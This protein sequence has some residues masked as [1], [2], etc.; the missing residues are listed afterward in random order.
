M[1]CTQSQLCAWLTNGLSGDDADN[2]TLLNHAAGRQVTAVALCADTFAGLASEH[3]TNLNLFNR[4]RVY[5]VC[6][7][8][9]D[10]LAS[11]YDKVAS[12]R[13]E[14]VVNGSP[15]KNSLAKR[16]DDLVLVLDCRSH[17]ASQSAAVFLGD[18]HI[19]R[20][21]HETTGKI[22]CVSCLQGGIGKTLTST[23]RRDEI[24]QHRH[25]FL[26]VGNDRVLDDFITR[27]SGFLRFCHQAS[28]AA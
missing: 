7:G 20:Y 3:G 17:Q 1:E 21:I 2:L 13:V 24:F 18:Y 14:Y 15:T 16:L 25:S 10:F 9:P 12:E 4:E 22:T 26:Q 5:Q 8:F 28:H 11:L 6:G 23:V 19:V 27:S